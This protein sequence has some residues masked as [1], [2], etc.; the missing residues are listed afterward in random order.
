MGLTYAHVI[1]AMSCSLTTGLVKVFKLA[2]TMLLVQYKQIAIA[3][4][5]ECL[6][7]NGGCAQICNNNGGSFQCDCENG[8]ELTNDSYTCIGM[9]LY[10]AI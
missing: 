6:T 8:Y 5:N 2:N 10:M 3:D 1:L 9:Q 4:V 7:D